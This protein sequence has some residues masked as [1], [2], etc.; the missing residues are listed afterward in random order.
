MAVLLVPVGVAVLVVFVEM[1][2][3]LL[4]FVLMVVVPMGRVIP[5]VDVPTLGKFLAIVRMG[6]VVVAVLVAMV[7]SLVPVVV[8][9]MGLVI[10]GVDVPALG[11][12]LALV[13]MVVVVVAVLMA[14]VVVAVLVAMVV[15]FVPV[16]VVSM[17]RVIPGVDMPSLRDFL[18]I[19]GMALVTG[20]QAN[21]EENGKGQNR[22]HS[23]YRLILTPHGSSP[24]RSGL[25]PLPVRRAIGL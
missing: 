11:K 10:P 6:V 23:E 2:M 13:R 19:V 18:L 25:R 8:A 16:V 20:W 5:G 1:A 12:F 24:N 15:G 14:M 4:G 3:P 9:P 21:N 22:G 17:G 7:V